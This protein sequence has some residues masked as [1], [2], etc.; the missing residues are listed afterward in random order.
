ME[1]KAYEN[2]VSITVM[3]FN[4]T[5]NGETLGKDNKK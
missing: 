1:S 2:P 3:Y 4:L 5:A